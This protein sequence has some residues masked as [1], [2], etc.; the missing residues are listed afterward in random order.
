M[1]T[2]VAWVAFRIVALE[3]D[4]SMPTMPIQALELEDDHVVVAQAANHKQMA[5]CLQIL[6][7]GRLLSIHLTRAPAINFKAGEAT[8]EAE[9]AQ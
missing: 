6:R 1:P 7:N 2:T 9:P 4:F 3:Q 8:L 5:A